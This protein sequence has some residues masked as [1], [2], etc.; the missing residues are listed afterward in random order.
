MDIIIKTTAD[1]GQALKKVRKEQRLTQ[2]DVAGL[3]GVSRR[4]IVELEG[5]KKT[6]QIGKALHV[7]NMLGVSLVATYKWEG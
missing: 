1:V 5:G 3:T 4:F 6:A 7:I 2:D